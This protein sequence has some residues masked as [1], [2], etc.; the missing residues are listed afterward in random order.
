MIPARANAN[1]GLL[2]EPNILERDKVI[3]G[4]PPLTEIIN[5]RGSISDTGRGFK[6]M[7]GSI[8][9]ASGES[10]PLSSSIGIFNP[11]NPILTLSG[12]FPT[13]TGSMSSIPSSSGGKYLTFTSSISDD[14]F[15]TPSLYIL[16]SSYDQNEGK[17]NYPLFKIESGGPE[18]IFRE[19]LQPN[20]SGSTISEHNMEERFFYTTQAS[21]SVN[22]FYSSSFVRSDKQSL[23]HDSQLIRLTFEGSTQTKRTTLDKL[24]PVTVVLTSPTTLKTKEGGESKLKVL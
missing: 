14:I 18:Y 24:E 4:A 19:V 7:P 10:K 5:F 2:I 13:Y 3:I 16:S 1:V 9:S 12:S 17:I 20:V 22:N 8:A 6:D 21:A 11:P 15:R 23:F